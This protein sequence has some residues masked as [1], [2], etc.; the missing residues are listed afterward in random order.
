M[1]ELI[2]LSFIDSA[3]SFISMKLRHN[4]VNY[5][6]N[7][8][9][10]CELLVTIVWQVPSSPLTFPYLPPA[11][12]ASDQVDGTLGDETGSWG[13]NVTLDNDTTL[14]QLQ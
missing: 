11:C 7:Y 5:Y 14:M 13:E 8:Y 1:L 4:Y 3:K 2:H 12:A 10:L 9:K 6:N